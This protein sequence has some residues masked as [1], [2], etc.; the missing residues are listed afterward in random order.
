MQSDVC[1]PGPFLRQQ[2]IAAGMTKHHLDGPAYHRL[3]GCVRVPRDTELT[4][5]VTARAAIAVV[6]DAVI[7]HFSA[8]RIYGAV[9][10]DTPEVHVS[11][12]HRSQR[13]RRQGLVVHVAADR[14]TVPRGSLVLTSPVQTFCDLADELNLI[15]LVVCGDSL[16]HR[17]CM[18]VDAAVAAADQ[19]TSGARTLARRAARLLRAG[20]ESPMETRVRLMLVLAGLP[21]PIVNLSLRGVT[22]LV[23]YRLD[24]SYPD[25]RLAVE[26]DG[27]QHAEDADQW[28]RDIA[29][30]EWLDD[31]H[32]RLLVLRATD[33]YDRPWE[34]VC[35]VA[36]VMATLGYEKSMP[37]QA[38][39]EFR[40]HFPGR[41]WRAA[42]AS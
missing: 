3:F 38:P 40:L 19:K 35:R 28:G 8:A 10:P 22:G 34:T 30:R 9:V 27:R 1:G 16:I 31:H 24:L 25:L 4:P 20:S 7:S 37:S 42:R 13:S 36:A 11:V 32:W 21:E 23:M 33:I 12:G 15:D 14:Q 6:P 29:R 26:Y 18:T 5:S 17:G 2:G 39:D 41:P